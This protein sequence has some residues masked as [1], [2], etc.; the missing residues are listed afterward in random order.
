[1]SAIGNLLWFV[2]G[3]LWL[4]LGW[5]LAGIICALTIVGLPWA[6]SCFVI[7]QFAFLPFGKEAISRAELNGY[8]DVGTGVLG[9]IGNVLWFLIA[10]VWMAIGHVVTACACFV[11]IIGIPFGIQHLKLAGLAL[12]PMGKTIVSKED[13]EAAR[14]YAAQASV[15]RRRS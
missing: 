6:K 14:L 10:G 13:A 1:M 4:G 12:A 8:E 9:A 5:W 11:T 15:A 3:G 2:F 7:G